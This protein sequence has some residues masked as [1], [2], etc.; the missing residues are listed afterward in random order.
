MLSLRRFPA[1]RPSLLLNFKEKRTYVHFPVSSE[2]FFAL[3]SASRQTRQNVRVKFTNKV[4]TGLKAAGSS[5]RSKIDKTMEQ[6]PRLNEL[7]ISYKKTRDNV[8][9]FRYEHS[10]SIKL[11][12]GGEFNKDLGTG[13]FDSEGKP[14]ATKTRFGRF[15]IPWGV[16][17]TKKRSVRRWQAKKRTGALKGCITLL[18]AITNTPPPY[19]FSLPPQSFSEFLCWQ[20][21]R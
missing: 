12:E 7:R 5:L 3:F 9:R 2:E 16:N 17:S 10:V 13:W 4:K 15:V 6:R 21:E 19:P 1:Y 8:R 11:P 20:W 18:C 14:L